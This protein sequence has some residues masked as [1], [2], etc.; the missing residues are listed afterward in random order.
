M[1]FVAGQPHNG[2]A[3]FRGVLGKVLGA[4]AVVFSIAAFVARR[5]FV[6]LAVAVLATV[7]VGSGSTEE[8]IIRI[9]L[10]EG[11]VKVGCFVEE[12]EECNEMLGLARP[13]EIR[14]RRVTSM[15]AATPMFTPEYEERRAG[16]VTERQ[17]RLAMLHSMPFGAWIRAPLYLGAA[18]QLKAKLEAQR[19]VVRSLKSREGSTTAQS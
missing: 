12:T 5:S 11:V 19:A 7:F 1:G 17:E 13:G 4:G 14:V 6:G 16:V 9:G 8:S 2:T 3:L 18:E 15:K 10:L